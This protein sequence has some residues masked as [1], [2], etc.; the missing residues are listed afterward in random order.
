MR[1]QTQLSD[2]QFHL[3]F[4]FHLGCNL[5]TCICTIIILEMYIPMCTCCCL[6]RGLIFLCVVTVDH[7]TVLECIRFQG[8]ERTIN[9][10]QEIGMNCSQF[11]ILL[12]NDP[13]GTRVYNIE[14]DYREIEQINTEIL[15]EWVT[16]RGKN[17]VSWETLI[18]VLHDIELHI[19]A[20][21]IEE[22]KLKTIL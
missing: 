15:R 9:I 1:A 17:P 22:V 3:W 5:Y 20:S 18:I 6:L 12:L 8:L 13:N 7:P 19:L 2:T 10:P 16:G 4:L 14:R 21:E 11:G